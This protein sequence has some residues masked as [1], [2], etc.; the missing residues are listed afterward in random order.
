KPMKLIFPP[1]LC[2][3]FRNDYLIINDPVYFKGLP[4]TS[5]F[6]STKIRKHHSSPLHGVNH[7]L[8]IP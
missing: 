8:I 6:V 4:L 3:A 1:I 7:V 2:D 5:L